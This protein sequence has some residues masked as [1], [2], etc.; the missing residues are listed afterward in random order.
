MAQAVAADVDWRFVGEMA[1][2]TATQNQ[3]KR[4]LTAA[5]WG[6]VPTSLWM[7]RRGREVETICEGCGRTKDLRHA[8]VGCSD[9]G[10]EVRK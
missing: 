7:A 2:R 6:V 5:A 8:M 3:T 1:T 9:D 4:I 10:E